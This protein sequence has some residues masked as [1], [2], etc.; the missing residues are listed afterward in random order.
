M[1]KKH[2]LFLMGI[3]IWGILST[4]LQAAIEWSGSGRVYHQRWSFGDGED[5]VNR[6]REKVDLFLNG[7]VQMSN[8]VR[9]QIRFRHYTLDFQDKTDAFQLNRANLTWNYAEGGFFKIGLMGVEGKNVGEHMRAYYNHRMG[10]AWHH[11]MDLGPG[12]VFMG[13]S[14]IV[15]GDSAK[16][17]IT[18]STTYYTPQLGYEMKMG[19]YHLLLGGTYH[20]YSSLDPYDFETGYVVLGRKKANRGDYAGLEFFGKLT[21]RIGELG[22]HAKY[23][24]FSNGEAPENAMD[25]VSATATDDTSDTAAKA[26]IATM[27]EDKMVTLM[28]FGLNYRKVH[29]MMEMNNSGTYGVNRAIVNKDWCGYDVGGSGKSSCDSMK[30]TVAYKLSDNL[31]PKLEFVQAERNNDGLAHSIVDEDTSLK[32]QNFTMTRLAVNFMF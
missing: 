17:K 29:L 10:M 13:F 23:A 19:D 18:D 16:G 24:M 9:A 25:A 31:M 21:G 1:I 32:D 5:S 11:Q 6:Q 20:L 2:S 26:A 27:D 4:S 28:G 30:F 3:F 12:S 15:L 7:E 14:R 22:W 8:N